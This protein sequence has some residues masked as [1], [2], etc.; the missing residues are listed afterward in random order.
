MEVLGLGWAGL[1][2]VG[3]V[4]VPSVSSLWKVDQTGSQ[5][6]PRKHSERLMAR[7]HALYAYPAGQGTSQSQ[8][9]AHNSGTSTP[10]KR[11]LSEWPGHEKARITPLQ[12]GS[13]KLEAGIQSVTVT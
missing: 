9:K 11:Y 10:P 5:A 8:A 7:G 6:K 3:G 4:Q 1:Q 13:Q 2:A 12:A